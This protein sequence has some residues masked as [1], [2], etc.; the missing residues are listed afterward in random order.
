MFS[1]SAH[2]SDRRLLD[3]HGLVKS[4]F[5]RDGSRAI[6]HRRNQR[7][8]AIAQLEA[9]AAGG[10]RSD[11]MARVIEDRRCD[12]PNAD[13]IFL[14]LLGVTSFAGA[15][16]LLA[17]LLQPVEHVLLFLVVGLAGPQLLVGRH[18]GRRL[19]AGEFSSVELTEFFLER[20]ATIGPQFNAVA[21]VTRE[22]ASA[23]SRR[24]FSLRPIV[25]RSATVKLS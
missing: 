9:H 20:L 2:G 19:R 11:Y 24:G 22:R 23:S 25:S 3:R 10:Y 18:P 21:T 4:H 15:L 12:S 17:R 14:A 6:L 8:D 7:L 1:P 5:C 16:Q 13:R